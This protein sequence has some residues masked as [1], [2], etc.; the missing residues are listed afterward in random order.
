MIIH[1]SDLQSMNRCGEQHRR[2]R[3]GEQGQQLS[4][5]AYGSVIH[6]A[7]HTLERERDLDLA[8][9]TFDHF[10]HPMN[11]DAV[12]KPVDVW[13]GR[14]S[15]GAMRQKGLELL[16]RYWD[17][18]QYDDTEEVLAL[19]IP[20]VVPIPGTPHMLG[21]T[22]DR[23]TVRRARGRLYLCIDDWKS[24]KKKS[25]LKHNVQHIAYA[26]ATTHEEFW[27][28]NPQFLTEGFGPERG[29]ELF[30]RFR[31]L[32]RR[33]Y[34]ID[35]SDTTPKWNDC[36]VKSEQ[37]YRRYYHAADHYARMVEAEIFPLNI[38][39]EVCEYCPF[40]DDCPEGI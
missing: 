13:I 19:E 4:A 28:G 39:G 5:T 32:P 22:I 29:R 26:E 31:D 18:K 11:I 10:W 3:G 36:G 33:G 7:L 14:Q 9:R 17:L 8:L 30:E 37:D 23:L 27:V 34:W 20:F 35:C 38:A 25:F 21:G 1:Q 2:Q 16:K 15:Y 40:R 24:G 6:H 12:C